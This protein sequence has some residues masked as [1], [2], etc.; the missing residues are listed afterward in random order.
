ME[1]DEISRKQVREELKESNNI[2]G[3]HHLMNEKDSFYRRKKMT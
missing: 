2:V 3:Q 1:S